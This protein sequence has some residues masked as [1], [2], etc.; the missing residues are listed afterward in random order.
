MLGVYSP[1]TSIQFDVEEDGNGA[2]GPKQFAYFINWVLLALAV[3]GG[4]QVAKQSRR[5]LLVDQCT[6]FRSGS[7]CRRLL[8]QHPNPDSGRAVD[9]CV[10]SRRSRVSCDDHLYSLAVTWPLLASK[11]REHVEAGPVTS[12][13][14]G[15]V[16]SS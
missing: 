13:V 1:T 4:L 7:E 9:R 8:R 10:G 15:I 5:Q 12:S 3:V 2:R 6:V 16:A 11:T 14:V